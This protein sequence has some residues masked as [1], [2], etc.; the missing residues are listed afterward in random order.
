MRLLA[1]CLSLCAPG[2]VAET[3]LSAKYTN[4]TTRYGH[5]I[6]GDAVEWGGLSITV[7]TEAENQSFA[8]TLPD[9]QVFEDLTPRLWDITGDG[10]PEVVVV[11][12]QIDLGASLVVIGLRDGVPVKIAA[13]PHIGRTNRWLAP[14]GAADLDNDGRLEVAYIDRPHLAKTLR[15]WEY[16]G[17]ALRLDAELAGLTNHRIG[18]DFITGGIRNCGAGPEI[19]TVDAGWQSVMSTQYDDGELHSRPLSDYTGQKAVAD[20]LACR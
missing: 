8:I 4:P 5:A 10:A 13:T 20:A 15:V 16:D 12:T 6:L 11:L 1:A 2:A 3:I 17:T 18:E 14:I 9:N 19:I 7:G